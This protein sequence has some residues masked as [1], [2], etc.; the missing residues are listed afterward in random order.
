MFP[1]MLTIADA[2]IERIVMYGHTNSSLTSIRVL[3]CLP[4]SSAA[5]IFKRAVSHV[6]SALTFSQTLFITVQTLPQFL[7]W[8]SP[9]ETWLPSMKARQVPVRQWILQVLVHTAGSLLNN[10]AFAF[11]VPLTIQ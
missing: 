5:C 11:R 7:T 9:R 8:Q 2:D 4:L 10:W 6:G 3:V 1:L